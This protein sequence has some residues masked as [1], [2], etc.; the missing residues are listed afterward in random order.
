[1]N[2]R[3]F[4][5]ELKVKGKPS[6]L[7][8]EAMLHTSACSNCEALQKVSI[9]FFNSVEKEKNAKPSP[10]LATRVM[11]HIE[12]KAVKTRPQLSLRAVLHVAA[13]LL[14]LISGFSSALLF[15]KKSY[16]DDADIIYSDYFSVNSGLEMESSWLNLNVYED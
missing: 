5:N 2:C 8:K 6:L 15:E 7:S 3:D 12:N 4:E 16:M 10:F 13:F 1:M 11:A 14:V 9:D